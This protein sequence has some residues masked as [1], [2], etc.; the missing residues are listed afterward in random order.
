MSIGL[1]GNPTPRGLGNLAALEPL[2]NTIPSCKRNRVQSLS[3]SSSLSD[4]RVSK[5]SFNSRTSRIAKAR[6]RRFWSASRLRY[7]GCHA[8][9][10]FLTAALRLAKASACSCKSS[11]GST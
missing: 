6:N 1:K 3:S 11:A 10:S 7:R 8:S 9:A 5:A 4:R 2:E